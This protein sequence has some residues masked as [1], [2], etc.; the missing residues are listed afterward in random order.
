MSKKGEN[1]DTKSLLIDPSLRIFTGRECPVNVVTDDVDGLGRNGDIKIR[2]VM[3]VVSQD[4]AHNLSAL[5]MVAGYEE[6]ALTV[7]VT[8]ANGV[9]VLNLLPHAQ[10]RFHFAR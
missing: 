3:L 10:L 5:G 9:T 7:K 8:H 1:R 2:C 6:V 4:D